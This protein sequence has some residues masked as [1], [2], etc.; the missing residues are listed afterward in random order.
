MQPQRRRLARAGGA[1]QHEELAVADV[2]GELVDR[3]MTTVAF[4]ELL[5]RYPSHIS[6]LSYNAIF[7]DSLVRLPKKCVR[8]S[9]SA[10]QTA[11]PWLRTNWLAVRARSTASPT[12]I[13]DVVGTERLD[14]VRLDRDV[15]GDC[16]RHDLH[17]LRRGFRAPPSP[18]RPFALAIC[19]PAPRARKVPASSPS[20]TVVAPLSGRT[21]AIDHVHDR[22]ADELCDEQV[23]RMLVHLG[24]GVVL[25]QHAVVHDADLV[26]HRHRFDLI[27]RHVDGGRV[28]LAGAGGATRRAFPRAAWRRAR[29]SARPS[30]SPSAA[31]PARGRSPRAAC[32]RRTAPRV[33]CPADARCAA[34]CDVA[35]AL[36][37]LA[38]VFV[39][40]AQRKGDVVVAVRCG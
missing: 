37:D 26:G 3:A 11:S 17:S 18:R 27:V 6:A 15:A 9:S 19:S 5:Q 21:L 2:Q 22:A 40:C 14:D 8:A 31:A 20:A 32:R 4:A 39:A 7:S 33:A 30:A 28:V 23:V 34:P 38:L 24:R 13:D 25:L 10:R 1:E 36:V 16:R 12:E 35:D 29:R